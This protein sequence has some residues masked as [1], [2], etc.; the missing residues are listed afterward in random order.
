MSFVKASFS[1]M[2]C[3][4]IIAGCSSPSENKPAI[5]EEEKQEPKSEIYTVE[6]VQM[7]FSPA[8][9]KVKKGD[10]IVFVNH[11]IVAHDVTEESAKKWTSAILQNGEYFTLLVTESANYYCSIHTVMKGKVIVE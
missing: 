1:V 2:I 8:E 11:D 9:I 4:L 10:Q 7:K 5:K 6:I 3:F